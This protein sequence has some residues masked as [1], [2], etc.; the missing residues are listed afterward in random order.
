[1]IPI[2]K[3]NIGDREKK[4]VQEVLDSGMIA[5]GSKVG[6]LEQL[7]AGYC[8]SKYA[9]ATNNGTSAL[10]TALHSLGI[11]KGD[12][13]ITT[14][15]TFIATGNSILM[16][17]GVPVFADIEKD[18]YNIDPESVKG[19]ITKKTKAILFVDLFGHMADIESLKKIAQEHN[20]MLIED[21]CQSHGAKF[22]DIT[23]GSAADASCF[24]L[25]ATKNM[26]SG[27]GGIMTTN[28][29]EVD[30]LARRF[31]HHGQDPK[32]MYKYFGLGY[33]Y[34]MT[35]IHA[36]IAIEQLKQIEEFNIARIKNAEMLT[37]GLKQIAWIKT[38]IVKPGCRHVFH[39]Y[40]IRIDEKIRDKLIEYLKENGIGS[41]VF[42]PTPLHTV[43]H[44]ESD[45]K[46]PVA[47]KA[48]KEVLSL[49]VH[50]QVSENDIKY[51]I[52]KIGDFDA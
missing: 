26:V 43:P 2:A 20:L 17:G 31:R 27:E 16:Q 19:K 28:N 23:A 35:D 18:T 8:K 45:D 48:S 14:P 39:Q 40:T 1:L 4:A 49:P 32:V 42:Y 12:E 9:V 34:R 50:P 11:N 37:A 3:P 21:A 5:Q 30:A 13:V 7:F 6:E 47:D 25:Y 15:F 22:H 38:P 41:G 24:S 44:M 52:G 33:N 46:C 10:H 51:I 29:A 36:A